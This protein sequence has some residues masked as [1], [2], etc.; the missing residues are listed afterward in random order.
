MEHKL[1]LFVNETTN[2]APQLLVN[3][4]CGTKAKLEYIGKLAKLCLSLAQLCPSLSCFVYLLL[5]SD[6]KPSTAPNCKNKAFMFNVRSWSKALDPAFGIPF[7][8]DFNFT[9]GS[10]KH[11]VKAHKY[12]LAISSP[13]FKD[14]PVHR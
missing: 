11:H 9:E 5:I 12:F 14:R 10:I 1:I 3:L 6:Q 8:V 7:D 13:V 4:L 2:Y